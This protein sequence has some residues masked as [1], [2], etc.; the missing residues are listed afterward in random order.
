MTQALPDRRLVQEG[1]VDYTQLLETISMSHAN[2]A[3]P[4]LM[5]KQKFPGGFDDDQVVVNDSQ[6]IYLKL[7]ELSDKKSD[8]RLKE[9]EENIKSGLVGQVSFEIGMLP[10]DKPNVT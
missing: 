4:I 7:K 5:T 10:L 3:M 1:D 8:K 6:E 2:S 9:A